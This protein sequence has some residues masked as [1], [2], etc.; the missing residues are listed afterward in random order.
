MRLKLAGTAF[1]T[2]LF[3]MAALPALAHTGHDA[4]SAVSGF[5]HPIMGVDHV[6]AML[7]VGLWAAL[8]GR[9]ALYL[10][11]LVF[12]LVMVVGGIMGMNGIALP[13]VE[14]AIALSGLILGLMVALYAKPQLWISALMVGTFALFHGHAHG[15]ELPAGAGAFGYAAGFVAGTAA[16]HL[17][18]IGLGSLVGAKAGQYVTRAAG[19][20]IALTGAA[21]LTGI[22]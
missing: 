14:P 12:P 2:T 10:L 9:P 1:A 15:A 8:Q 22:A 20:V 19:M 13:Y 6:I 7:A 4:S 17:A 18:G 11:P 3:T 16:L 5:L 21:F